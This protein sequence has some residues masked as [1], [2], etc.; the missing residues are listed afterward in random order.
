MHASV[1]FHLPLGELST[2]SEVGSE[3]ARHAVDN[4][5]CKPR[6]AH[7]CAALLEQCLLM[8]GIVRLSVRNVVQAIGGRNA[9][10]SWSHSELC[11]SA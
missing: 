10:G 8:L 3:Q 5:K 6:F 2:S 7:H 4:H 11:T 9:L 1:H